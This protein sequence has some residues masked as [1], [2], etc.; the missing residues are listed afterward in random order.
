M[1]SE[2]ERVRKRGGGG[3]WEKV[4]DISSKTSRITNIIFNQMSEDSQQIHTTQAHRDRSLFS[5]CHVL[6]VAMSPWLI[7][8]TELSPT[9]TAGN[10]I[11]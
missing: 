1:R 7:G 9:G 11:V 3:D 5:D 10:R 8:L 2:E 4:T 6:Q